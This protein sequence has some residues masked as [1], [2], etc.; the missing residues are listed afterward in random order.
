MKVPNGLAEKYRSGQKFW[1]LRK[2][3]YGLKQ[4]GRQW[5]KRL[6]Q[7]MTK[8]GF[9]HA[10]ADDC[11]YVLWEHGKII[12]M[13][14]IY[15]DDMAVAGKGIPGIVLFKQNLSKDFEIMDLGKIKFI[16]GIQVTRDQSNYLLF[17]NQFAYITQI[18]VRFGMLDVKPVLT[19]LAVK[20]GLSMSQSP[21]S[22][23]ELNEYSNFSGGIH[24]L[25]LVGSL[26][27]ATQTHLNVQFS[28]NLVAQFSGNP[29]I[30]HLEA[31]K[32]ILCYFKGTQD[33]S[34]VLGRQGRGAMDI[35]GQTDSDWAS[36]VDS[37]HSVEGFVFDVA[38]GCVSWSLKKQVSVATSSMEAE[39]VVS[40][41]ATKEAVWL[42][43]LLKEVSY[44][45]SQA[46]IVHADNQG[47]I[48]LAQ[49]PTSYSRAKHIDIHFYFIQECIERNKI[50]LQYISTHQMVTDILTKALPC[51]AFEKFCEALG[52]VKVSH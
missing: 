13:V 21:S 33:F 27:Y 26:L 50:K 11:L 20:H 38:G 32:H 8:L 37:R 3:L 12:L 10:M 14:L 34:L 15:I 7:V 45:Q 28:V 29:G 31:A 47:A 16:L 40:A 19:P 9:T 22:E 36:D 30:P 44:P 39:Y 49:N 6:H 5:K 2:A 25:S 51:E 4:A 46:T 23:A 41:N 1:R 17:L 48:A 18:L 24:Y 35:V 43:T 42:R 52:V